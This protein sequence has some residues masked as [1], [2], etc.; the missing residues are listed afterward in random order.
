[1][2]HYPFS[3]FHSADPGKSQVSGR[4]F[5]SFC[6]LQFESF[7]ISNSHRQEEYGLTSQE[8]RGQSELKM[9]GMGAVVVRAKEVMVA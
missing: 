8:A 9:L 4:F 3:V 1:M 5:F 6:I 2:V 7:C